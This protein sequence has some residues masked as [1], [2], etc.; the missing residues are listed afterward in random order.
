MFLGSTLFGSIQFSMPP[1]TY[2]AQQLLE[3]LKEQFPDSEQTHAIWEAVVNGTEHI[4]CGALAGVGKTFTSLRAILLAEAAQKSVIYLAFNKAIQVEA[5]ATLKKIKPDSKAD[6]KTFNAAGYKPCMDEWP[7]LRGMQINSDRTWY[8][9]PEGM[10]P[11]QKA[12][13]SRLVGLVKNTL[14][15]TSRDSL[16]DL[17]LQYDIQLFEDS[18]G[19]YV[20]T[21]LETVP[22]LI[23]RSKTPTPDT[24]IDFNDQVWLPVVW[25]LPTRTYDLV[26]VDEAQDLNNCRRSLAKMLARV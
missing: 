13:I 2:G 1:Y 25:Q 24:G 14:S 26:V 17:C 23:E 19:D 11:S 6:I 10:P 3:Q 21:V 5:D 7:F 8:M 12:I 16:L 4:E 18:G 20:D 15:S 22:D 9:L